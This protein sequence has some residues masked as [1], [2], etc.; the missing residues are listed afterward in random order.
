[1]DTVESNLNQIEKGYK[2]SEKEA[3]NILNDRK[4]TQEKVSLA[5]DKAASNKGKLGEVWDYLQSFFSIVS[6]YINGRYKEIPKGSIIAIFASLLY[7]LSPIDF[8]PDFI[9]GI[10]FIDDI[11]VIGLV[12]NQIKSDLNDYMVWKAKNTK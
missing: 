1:M 7:F 8:I 12:V 4:L 10:G 9:P 2:M 5:I 11:F 3:E 6:D